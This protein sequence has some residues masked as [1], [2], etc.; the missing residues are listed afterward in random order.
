M[1][2]VHERACVALRARLEAGR[3]ALDGAVYKQRARCA[4]VVT[5]RAAVAHVA[6]AHAGALQRA[7]VARR[8]DERLAGVRP[9]KAVDC[10]DWRV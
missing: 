1:V 10:Q 6:G 8:L 9:D 4:P 3:G 2:T 7:R 5:L